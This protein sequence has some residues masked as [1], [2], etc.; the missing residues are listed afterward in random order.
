MCMQTNKTHDRALPEQN[1]DTAATLSEIKID[2]PLK[3]RSYRAGE[4]FDDQNMAIQAIY[5]DGSTK[6]LELSACEHAAA[7]LKIG[8]RTVEIAYSENGIR[9]SAAQ[10]VFVT[11]PGHSD[12]YLSNS[13]TRAGTGS[14]DLYSKNILFAHSDIAAD[15]L[16]LPFSVSH[17]YSA[18]RADVNDAYCGC[19]WQT[20]FHQ[21]IVS[22]TA[23]DDDDAAYIWIDGSGRRNKIIHADYVNNKVVYALDDNRSTKYDPS[24]RTLTD[25]NGNQ[26]K[27]NANGWLIE[28]S[29]PDGYKVTI[30]YISGAP[31]KISLISEDTT[32]A[33]PKEF[34]FSYTNSLLSKISFVSMDN[35]RKNYVLFTYDANDRLTKISYETA[36]GKSTLFTYDSIGILASVT[37]PTGHKLL[38]SY[39]GDTVTVQETPGGI[40]KHSDLASNAVAAPDLPDRTWI[41]TFGGNTRVNHNGVTTV[42]GF[43]AKNKYTYSF[44]DRSSG[45][46]L[47]KLDVTGDI[48]FQQSIDVWPNL[49]HDYKDLLTSLVKK[50]GSVSGAIS[51]SYTNLAKEWTYLRNSPLNMHSLEDCASAYVDGEHLSK[52]G[53]AMVSHASFHR[54]FATANVSGKNGYIVSAFVKIETQSVDCSLS[55][56]LYDKDG[57]VVDYGIWELN[58]KNSEWQPGVVCLNDPEQKGTQIKIMITSTNSVNSRGSVYADALRVVEGTFQK[59]TAVEEVPTKE[60]D[61]SYDTES[62]YRTQKQTF[63]T[64][65]RC[66]LSYRIVDKVVR[67][68]MQR[69]E[70]TDEFG[71]STISTYTY[72]PNNGKL[73]SSFENGMTHSY[74]YMGYKGR[75]SYHQRSKGGVTATDYIAASLD[76]PNLRQEQSFANHYITTNLYASQTVSEGAT[77]GNDLADTLYSYSLQND[78]TKMA[79]DTNEAGAQN[80]YEYTNFLL[81]KVTAGN[82]TVYYS[83]DGYGE[84]LQVNVNGVLA[85]RYAYRD[86]CNYNTSSA[87]SSFNYEEQ[88]VPSGE[89][90][91]Y[92]Q[93]VIYNEDGLPLKKQEKNGSGAYETLV[94]LTYASADSD[95]YKEGELKQIT[96]TSSGEALTQT[97]S[98]YKQY[99]H[100]VDITY[101]GARSGK[102]HNEPLLNGKPFAKQVEIDEDLI[103]YLNYYT[104]RSNINPTAPTCELCSISCIVNGDTWRMTPDYGV[105]NLPV[106]RTVYNGNDVRMIKD[107]YTYNSNYRNISKVAHTAKNT[108]WA[109][110]EFAYDEHKRISEYTDV[111]GKTHRYY[112]DELSRLQRE[113][114]EVFGFTTFYTYNGGNITSVTKYPYTADE[115][116]SG[117]GSTL[118]YHYAQGSDKLLYTIF[119]GAQQ[120]SFSYDSAGNPLLW[121]GSVLQWERGRQLKEFGGITFTY[122]AGG[123]RQSKTANGV[124]T[125]YFTE[126]NRIHREER[127]DGK[128][129]LYAYDASGLASITYNGTLYFVQKNFQGDIVALVNQNGNVVAKY[130]YDAWGNG[131]VCNASGTENTSSSFIGNINPFRYRGYYYDVET[132]LYY[133]QTRYYEPRAGRFLNADSVDYIAPDLIGGLNL[134]AYCNNNPVMYSDPTGQLFS[135]LLIGALIG[136][137][138]NFAISAT[139]QLLTEGEVNWGTAVIDGAFGAVSGALAVTGIGAVAT[140]VINGALSLVNSTITTGIENNWSFSATDAVFIGLSSLASGIISGITRGDALKRLLPVKSMANMAQTGINNAIAS[141]RGVKQMSSA[142]S[143]YVDPHILRYFTDDLAESST[144]NFYQTM[145]FA[146]M[147]IGVT[148]L[149]GGSL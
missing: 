135:M 114:D 125:S 19:G 6:N 99:P 75:L 42:V 139:T 140:G 87:E 43:S 18:E 124:T 59:A 47:N 1:A 68:H 48:E 60:N 115:F 63:G 32:A 21:R 69:Q 41:M 146:S 88:T 107:A 118:T 128:T 13:L 145:M 106:G 89:G 112:Y 132:G 144:L 86:D 130:V 64:K 46:D 70:Y 94:T 9:K 102:I 116:P 136:F 74:A 55:A 119:D 78:L 123:V 17:T 90:S 131:K 57:N 137:A 126:G 81:T 134:Y 133:L 77:F 16:H 80:N 91:T 61:P 127:S 12:K 8:D 50:V 28:Q 22:P 149:M 83:Y 85:K 38:Y 26:S 71:N 39:D 3:Q 45:N 84:L 37:D 14:L 129:L 73:L 29:T 97:F 66:D 147:R 95:D 110:E 4:L 103:Q 56:V 142:M 11:R 23:T 96:D 113:D 65:E 54:I 79:A 141:G 122:D 67:T 30:T 120:Q 35:K 111:L 62:Y 109:T 40:T 20:N 98:Y 36:N 121:N 92:S 33:G 108:V 104:P 2:R 31:G 27:F 25:M 105:L 7:P 51:K 53:G 52:Q 117:T 72:D 44:T 58:T 76:A 101:S 5:S 10:P 24:A 138:V 100:I 143:R 15:T 82:N 34:T 93:K 49:N 148:G